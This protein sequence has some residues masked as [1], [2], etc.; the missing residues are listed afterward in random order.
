MIIAGA[1]EALEFQG[2][3]GISIAAGLC[4]APASNGEKSVV[5]ANSEKGYVTIY[6]TNSAGACGILVTECAPHQ[7]S[8]TSDRTSWK[9]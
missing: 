1:S 7:R 5:S 6:V 8:R 3:A 2:F 9:R 4:R